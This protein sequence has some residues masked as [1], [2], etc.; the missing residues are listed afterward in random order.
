VEFICL[1][2]GQ[3]RR[4]GRLGAYLQKCMY[5]VG[6]RPFLEHTLRQWRAGASPDP[7]RDELTLVV[8]HHGAQVRGYFGDDYGGVPIRYVEQREPL[9]TADAINAAVADLRGDESA[10]V[11]L[12][13]LFVPREAFAALLAHPS[14]AVATIAPGRGDEDPRLRVSRSGE[15][16]VRVWEGSEPR[17]DVGLWK[18]PLPVLRGLRQVRADGG[19]YRVLPNLQRHVDAGLQVGFLEIERWI[20]LGGT[21]P[22]AEEN[23]RD[24]VARVEAAS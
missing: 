23:L 4:F 8:G 12:A 16:L 24:V 7:V 22:T 2:A 1:A 5:P 3:G 15:R 20:H 10:V 17:Y 9:G 19:E 13:D 21:E 18:L 6:L 11:W 14:T